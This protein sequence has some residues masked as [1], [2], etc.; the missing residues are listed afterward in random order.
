MPYS[1]D[2]LAHYGVVGMHWGQRSTQ[3]RN[4]KHTTRLASKDAKKIC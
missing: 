3:S 1:N 2:Y 4:E